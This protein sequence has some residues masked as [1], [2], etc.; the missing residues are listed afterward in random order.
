[1]VSL[2]VYVIAA[3]FRLYSTINRLQKMRQTKTL[4]YSSALLVV[5]FL[6]GCTGTGTKSTPSLLPAMEDETRT[7]VFVSRRT[8]YAGSARLMEVTIDGASIGTLGNKEAVSHDVSAGEHV[9]QVRQTGPSILNEPTKIFTVDEGQK[10]Y[11]VV[12]LTT[13][14]FK[15]TLKLTAVT[16]DSFLNP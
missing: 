6:Y 14:F 11:F 1:M 15:N 3:A 7:A 2:D 4:V 12:D 16:R 13:G 10:A 9:V 5:L 8:G